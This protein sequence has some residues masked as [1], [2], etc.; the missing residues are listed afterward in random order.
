MSQLHG[1][2]LKNQSTSLNKLSGTGIVS[3]TAS[4]IMNF[5][6]GAKLTTVES[7]INDGIDVVNKAYVD[8]VAT[9][10]D[11]KQS[12]RAI[13]LANITGTYSNGV[14]TGVP[15][16]LV[17]DGVTASNSNRIVLNGQTNKAHNGI[18]VYDGNTTL[19]RSLDFD[20]PSEITGGQFVFITEG[21][22]YADTGWVVSTP[23]SAIT[24]GTDPIEFTQF[25]SAG[26]ITA[27]DG[28]GQTGNEFFVKTGTGLTTSNDQVIIATTGVSAASYG[29]A[30][31]VSTFTV[32]LEGQL[33]S[34]GTTNIAI[35]STQVTD[36]STAA[37]T[38]VLQ[39]T[40]FL[41]STTIDFQVTNGATV[42]AVIKPSSISEDL[43][44]VTNSPTTG[45]VLT[46]TASG[47]FIWVDP[48]TIGD[49]TEVVA[50]T[51][52]T[53]GGDSGSVTLTVQATNGLNV[54]ATSDAVELGG[55]L[56]KNTVINGGGN[57]DLSLDD[58]SVFG[59]TSSKNVIYSD[60]ETII[61]AGGT[62]NLSAT[63]T[64]YTD[65]VSGTK[66]GIRYATGG[67][68]TDIRSLTDKE[69]VDNAIAAAGSAATTFAGDGL[70]KD[71]LTFSV[72]PTIAGDG[73]TYSSGV[74]DVNVGAGLAISNDNVVVD[75]AANSG[76]TF[77]GGD[78]TINSTIAGDG[79][80]FLN[81]VLSV[82]AGSAQPQ[83]LEV[84]N[85]AG[86][87]GT[88]IIATPSGINAYSRL[89]VYVNGLKVTSGGTVANLPAYSGQ[90][91]RIDANNITW[92]NSDYPL[93][94]TD[95][96]EIVFEK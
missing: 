39:D 34:A 68:V 94:G 48:T 52:L 93:E 95:I 7:N 42:S 74:L 3:F 73:L 83:Y 87:S 89:E 80:T 51:G 88:I 79:L 38:A 96:I 84:T 22:I 31:A 69:Y 59:V 24:V 40:N 8:S 82:D 78:L 66:T 60:G 21:S 70:I 57:L 85:V 35:P 1:K 86:G 9:G 6:S 28:L 12:A 46:A 64:T 15:S 23:D 55:T 81:G 65:T 44:N 49:I 91:V 92:L 5:N 18:Y 58:I 26:V 20:E 41:D 13:S 90:S 62:L 50:G 47:Q 30:T 45:W 17:I 67:Y 76:L 11:V 27:G 63:S 33:T 16:T 71:G 77:T 4:S 29:S 2:Q 53:G 56:T 10:L 32:N 75:L 14:I 54:D 72:A 37:E 25:S 19:T 61:T 43:L 36:F